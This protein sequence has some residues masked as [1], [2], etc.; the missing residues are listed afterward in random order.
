MRDNSRLDSQG[1]APFGKVRSEG[2]M[3]IVDMFGIYE[4]NQ[5]KIMNVGYDWTPDFLTQLVSVAIIPP[6]QPICTPPADPNKVAI[7]SD[8]D[9]NVWENIKSESQDTDISDT[10]DF[11]IFDQ[12]F[13]KSKKDPYNMMTPEEYKKHKAL[14]LLNTP[15]P[16]SY[17]RFPPRPPAPPTS[18]SPPPYVAPPPPSDTR[19]AE[20]AWTRTHAGKAFFVLVGL[21]S[22]IGVFT[23]MVVKV[24]QRNIEADRQ[25]ELVNTLEMEGTSAM[26]S[27]DENDDEEKHLRG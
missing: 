10:D 25:R 8:S 4:A 19:T 11:A 20:I 12:F 15:W 22:L 23:C 1:F 9:L 16:P 3:K 26:D 7:N 27:D 14:L 17:P 2:M 6:K 18:P 21:V 5:D 24:L 13:R